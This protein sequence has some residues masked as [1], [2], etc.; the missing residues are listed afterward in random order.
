MIMKMKTAAGYLAEG[1]ANRK[2][3]LNIFMFQRFGL[4]KLI[5]SKSVYIF[6]NSN[7]NIG[8]HSPISC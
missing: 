4:V 8:P 5:F 7:Q 1:K 2:E 6:L 3:K